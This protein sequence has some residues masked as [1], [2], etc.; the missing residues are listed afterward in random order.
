[1]QENTS[2]LYEC[3]SYGSAACMA[4][5]LQNGV[6]PNLPPGLSDEDSV[7]PLLEALQGDGATDRDEW[8]TA[9][10]F[11]LSEGATL[12]PDPDLTQQTLD[13]GKALVAKR[14]ASLSP[15]AVVAFRSVLVVAAGAC[16]YAALRLL[17]N[18]ERCRALMNEV[19]ALFSLE[20]DSHEKALRPVLIPANTA[21]EFKGY[22][23]G[24]TARVALHETV[25][26][27]AELAVS[28][29]APKCINVLRDMS[30]M[31]AKSV[32]AAAVCAGRLGE[33]IRLRKEA[34]ADLSAAREELE[35][36]RR[37][38]AAASEVIENFVPNGND[39]RWGDESDDDEMGLV[40][41]EIGVESEDDEE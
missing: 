35:A 29:A 5:L 39:E 27:F 30:K 7:S 20:T 40:W 34:H 26:Q 25:F 2:P 37:D 38:A 12:P 4:V 6:S 32:Y 36:A 9:V 14:F 1:M 13:I 21:A 17:T 15:E 41:V 11:L 33:L 24:V 10:G 31:S 19:F 28:D 3:A 22:I 23:S 8:A 16:P 18:K